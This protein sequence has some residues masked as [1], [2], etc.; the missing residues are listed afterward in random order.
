MTEGDVDFLCET[1]N[2]TQ[3]GPQ[4]VL[5]TE[6]NGTYEI[7]KKTQRI[8]SVFRSI[9]HKNSEFLSVTINSPSKLHT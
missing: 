4:N 3:G 8:E 7:A 2:A 6:S 9:D 5:S 1:E